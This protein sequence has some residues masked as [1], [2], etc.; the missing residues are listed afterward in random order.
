MRGG[1]R[2][3]LGKNWT[4]PASDSRDFS[5]VSPICHPTHPPPR[6]PTYHMEAQEQIME[7]GVAEMKGVLGD[8]VSLNILRRLLRQAK[9]N[10]SSALNTYFD[11]GSLTPNDCGENQPA[12][13]ASLSTEVPGSDANPRGNTTSEWPKLLGTFDVLGVSLSKIRATELHAGAP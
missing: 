7:M 4:L 2:G 6:P 12:S 9:G 5:R 10:V 11:G 1:D 13:I 8:S 3:G